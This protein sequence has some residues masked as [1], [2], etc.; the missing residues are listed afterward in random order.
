MRSIIG[1]PGAVPVIPAETEN[2][3]LL[4]LCGATEEEWECY[5]RMKAYLKPHR[6]RHSLGVMV[7]ALRMADIFGYVPAEKARLAGLIHDC[8][9]SE[10]NAGNSLDHAPAG[11]EKARRDFG[12]TD[13]EV[14]GAIRWHTTGRP[15]MTQLEK[16]IYV[17]DYIEPFREPREDLEEARRIAGEDLDRAVAFTAGRTVQYLNSRGKAIDPVTLDCEAYYRAFKQKENE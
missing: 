15:G 2:E 14:L 9:R 13:E 17:A 3:A 11:A 12:I 5:R 10:Q 8:G 6:L 1:Q 16:I 4:E 7:T